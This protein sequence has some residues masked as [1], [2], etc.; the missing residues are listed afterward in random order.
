MVIIPEHGAEKKYAQIE[1]R[2]P[3]SPSKRPTGTNQ[4]PFQVESTTSKSGPSMERLRDDKQILAMQ[5][6]FSKKSQVLERIPIERM[7]R[8]CSLESE[9]F[10]IPLC[11]IRIRSRKRVILG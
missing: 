7:E 5:V 8:I 3:V 10:F 1:P 4:K 2:A 11:S 9:L 6:S